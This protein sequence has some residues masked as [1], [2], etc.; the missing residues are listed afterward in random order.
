MIG[1]HYRQGV[2]PE[3]SLMATSG[4]PFPLGVS[5]SRRSFLPHN[6]EAEPGIGSSRWLAVILLA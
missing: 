4:P 3:W 5:T 1:R 6:A 2:R